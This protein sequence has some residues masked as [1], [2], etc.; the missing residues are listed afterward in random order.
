MNMLHARPSALAA[1]DAP[2]GKSA[3]PLLPPRTSRDL[4]VALAVIVLLG[5]ARTAPTLAASRVA[6]WLA[7]LA[8]AV[9]FP[10]ATLRPLSGRALAAVVALWG[11]CG[12][13]LESLTPR[14]V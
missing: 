9:T 4:A 8:F 6:V 3:A 13:V 5:V 10:L 14:G 1:P 2:G 7:A 12:V 11:V